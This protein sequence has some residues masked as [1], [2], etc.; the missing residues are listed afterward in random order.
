MWLLLSLCRSEILLQQ[1]VKV[2]LLPGKIIEEGTVVREASSKKR[3][4][5]L[6][7]QF[8]NMYKHKSYNVHSY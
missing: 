4:E 7:M 5:L 6:N 2:N 8:T 3:S 1:I